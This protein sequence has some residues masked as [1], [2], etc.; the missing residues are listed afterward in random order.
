MDEKDLERLERITQELF[1]LRTK[2]Q[3]RIDRKLAKYETV[4]RIISRVTEKGAYEK[5]RDASNYFFRELE[6]LN[7]EIEDIVKSYKKK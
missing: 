1:D 5:T 2:A 7:S 3:A 4:A 6:R